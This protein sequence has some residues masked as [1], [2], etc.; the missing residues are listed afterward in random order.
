MLIKQVKQNT[1]ERG[2]KKISK[3]Q[4][5]MEYIG[6]SLLISQFCGCKIFSHQFAA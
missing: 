5:E 6:N 4:V 3:G 2:Y 1:G